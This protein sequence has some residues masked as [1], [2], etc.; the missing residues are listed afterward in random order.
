MVKVYAAN[1]D[2][3]RLLK[4]PVTKVGFTGMGAA[5]NWPDDTFTKRRI[6]DGDITLEAAVKKEEEHNHKKKHSHQEE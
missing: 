6:R 2:M 5:A 1:E 3:A 4:H